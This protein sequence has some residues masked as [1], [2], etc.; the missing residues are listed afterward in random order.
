MPNCV[1]DDLNDQGNPGNP[2]NPGNPPANSC[3]NSTCNEVYIPNPFPNISLPEIQFDIAKRINNNNAPGKFMK[4]E[5]LESNGVYIISETNK[6][7][8]KSVVI[9]GPTKCADVTHK[10]IVVNNVTTM[11][12]TDCIIIDTGA[13]NIYP[14]CD[15]EPGFQKKIIVEYLVN[16]DSCHPKSYRHHFTQNTDLCCNHDAI[17]VPC[18]E[19]CKPVITHYPPC[20][21]HCNPPCKKKRRKNKKKCCKPEPCHKPDPCH[22]E[23]VYNKNLMFPLFG[24]PR[25][26]LYL[27]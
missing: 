10:L 7:Y 17:K 20:N 1:L 19:P 13:L 27:H 4:Y 6:L 14:G 11:D 18:H 21:T 15:V 22:K 16:G 25:R 26:V 8:I 3:H 23:I 2:A 24:V 5:F 12:P 9:C